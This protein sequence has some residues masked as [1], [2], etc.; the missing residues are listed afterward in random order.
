MTSSED[1]SLGQARVVVERGAVGDRE[2][3]QDHE[4][5]EGEDAT[6]C[7]V[8]RQPAPVGVL[9]E[10]DETAPAGPATC[11]GR[12]SRRPRSGDPGRRSPRPRPRGAGTR[13]QGTGRSP[14]V[15]SSAGP[16]IPVLVRATPR[17]SP[18]ANTSIIRPKTTKLTCWTQPF[19]P[20]SSALTG[21]A[22]GT[23][24][25]ASERLL[26][27]EG[28]REQQR[29]DDA[30][31]CTQADRAPPG[32]WLRGVAARWSS[33]SW[34]RPSPSAVRRTPRRTLGTPLARGIGRTTQLSAARHGWVHAPSACRPPGRTRP[35]ASH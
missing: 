16:S 29:P 20:A 9:R 5:D 12:T 11:S 15:P 10:A 24:L 22:T 21:S 28:Q 4:P 34:S 6:R 17:F 19:G 35:G 26:D 14:A 25:V 7:G 33:G 13:P 18:T 1:R 30:G 2:A 23:E 27:E 31:Q 32:R 8:G 3:T